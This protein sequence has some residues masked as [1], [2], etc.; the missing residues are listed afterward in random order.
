MLTL[1]DI[2]LLLNAGKRKKNSAKSI[3]NGYKY[4]NLLKQKILLRS[5]LNFFLLN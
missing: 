4:K 1:F 5:R 3:Y 2:I